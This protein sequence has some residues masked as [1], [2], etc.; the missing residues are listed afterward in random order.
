MADDTTEPMIAPRVAW[1]A[2]MDIAT[3]TEMS[4]AERIAAVS[5]TRSDFSNHPFLA[6]RMKLMSGVQR[7]FEQETAEKIAG[8]EKEKN[9][10]TDT[11]IDLTASECVYLDMAIRAADFKGALTFKKSLWRTLTAILERGS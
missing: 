5:I 11:E 9:V 3:R 10:D 7:S 4:L 8:G 1:M 2:V 6:M